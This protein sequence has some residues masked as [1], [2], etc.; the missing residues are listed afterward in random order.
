VGFKSLWP[1]F[2]IE[3]ASVYNRGFF[4]WYGPD[5]LI[6]Y[7]KV[8]EGFALRTEANTLSERTLLLTNVGVSVKM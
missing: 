4:I 5:L 3:E 8:V 1:Y 7:T 2:I 6:L